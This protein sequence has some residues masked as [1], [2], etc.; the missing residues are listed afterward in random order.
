MIYFVKL[1]PRWHT[2]WFM[3]GQKCETHQ[4]SVSAALEAFCSNGGWKSDPPE[5]LL[6]IWL[7]ICVG[8]GSRNYCSDLWFDLRQMDVWQ[9]G[10]DS[11]MCSLN[12]GHSAE[13][14]VT[15]LSVARGSLAPLCLSARPRPPGDCGLLFTLMPSRQWQKPSTLTLMCM[16]HLRERERHVPPLSGYCIESFRDYQEHMAALWLSTPNLE[17]DF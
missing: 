13:V 16:T 2:T 10:E 12:P 3:V 7:W 5:L 9:R 14:K 8:G 17:S 15:C 6:L 4:W 11:H 1:L